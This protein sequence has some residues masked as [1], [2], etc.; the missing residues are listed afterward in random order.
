[1]IGRCCKG[2]V[3]HAVD[4][5]DRRLDDNGTIFVGVRPYVEIGQ[6]RPTLGRNTEDP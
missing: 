3:E 4:Y 5:G 2:Q 1:M 6:D